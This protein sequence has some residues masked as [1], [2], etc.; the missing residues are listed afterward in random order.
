MI[1]NN[2]KTYTCRTAFLILFTVILYACNRD[3]NNPGWDYFPDMFY[4]TA[5][6]TYSENPNFSDG[7]TMR[8]PVPG[9]V[10]RDFIPFDYT[11]DTDSRTR[12]GIEL[13]NPYLPA[14]DL[15][16]RGREVYSIFCADC[17][18]LKGDGEGYLFT[19]GLYSLKPRSLTD[20]VA[21][22]LKDGEIFHTIT[23]GLGFMGAHGSQV[24]PDDR[25]KMIL[26][27][28]E[29]QQAPAKKEADREDG[30]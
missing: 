21:V 14:A 5:Y 17:H 25:W 23:L 19:A 7:M 1:Q 8:E 6:E 10:A 26:Y 29:M 2:P 22:E 13:L 15:L 4:S 3:R 18:G 11:S 24:K 16:N 9:T 28:R 27:I 12:A 30:R 20:S